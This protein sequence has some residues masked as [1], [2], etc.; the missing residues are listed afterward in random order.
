VGGHTFDTWLPPDRYA[1]DH[2]DYWTG[3]YACLSHPDVARLMAE[4]IVQWL[5]E[6]PEV[7]AV[8]L[9]HNDGSGF[10]HCA[11]C[12][13]QSARGADNEARSAYTRTYIRFTNQ[14]AA[15]V[16]RR[17]PTVL[18]S[19]LA[20]SHV[21]DCPAGAEP[22]GPNVL[23]GL[24]LFPRPTQRT[25]RPLE[26]SPQELDR[27][28]RRQIPA[29]QKLSTHF[30]I[31][32]YYTLSN[33]HEAWKMVKFWSM[34]SMIH[35]DIRFLRRSGVAGLSSDQWGEGG[36]YP[37]NMYAFGKWTWDP[38]LKAE[39]IIEDFCRR[40]YGRASAPM[41]A[42]WNLL[43]EG[44]RESWKTSVPVNWRDQQRAVWIQKA[45]LQADS[46]VVQDRIRAT[47]A[48]HKSYW[49]E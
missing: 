5:D 34:V 8:D 37:L 48:M 46:K 20:Y 24:C 36:W 10:C 30:Y 2:P 6:N 29:W 47:F 18:V 7:D 22:L 14:V 16:A 25:M 43:E 32:E 44:L 17:H 35:Q 3:G 13:R 4:N 12:T 38:D 9:W 39:E 19:F 41:I 23:A 1:K 27:N 28:L 49:P 21:T 42:Y 26:T 45:L 15:L 31:Y 40:Y 11:K 33:R